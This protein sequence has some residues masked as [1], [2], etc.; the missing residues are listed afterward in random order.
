VETRKKESMNNRHDESTQ[1]K[2][3]AGHNPTRK[4][5]LQPNRTQQQSAAH[6]H[7]QDAVQHK[8]CSRSGL[9]ATRG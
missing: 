3:V 1:R 2:Q 6:N 8:H 9:V 7:N 4:P 5:A